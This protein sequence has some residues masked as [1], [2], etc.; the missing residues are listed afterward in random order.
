MYKKSTLQKIEK[1]LNTKFKSSK[2]LKSIILN[3]PDGE[4]AHGCRCKCSYC[5]WKTHPLAQ[6]LIYPDFNM[7]DKYLK[8]HSGF[9]TISGGGDPLYN[10][11]KNLG[12]LAMLI[13]YL[14]ERRFFVRIITR[15]WDNFFKL[16]EIYPFLLGSFSIDN[17]SQLKERD[18]FIEYSIVLNK[19]IVKK[20]IQ[21]RY[22]VLEGH[23]IIFREPL[24]TD[25]KLTLGMKG[26]LLHYPKGEFSTEK[27]CYEASYLVNN[28]VMLGYDIFK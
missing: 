4:N 6:D 23:R 25:F 28:K 27:M 14:Y 18:E 3:F 5:N 19:D 22:K 20:I 9:V 16:K 21:S 15:E 17:F 26:L 1:Q 24:D 10:L 7:L 8:G 2:E 11:D 12:R 13:E